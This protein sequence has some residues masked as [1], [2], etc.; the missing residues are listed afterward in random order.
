MSLRLDG[1]GKTDASEMSELLLSPTSIWCS[2]QVLAQPSPVPEAEGIYAW[3]FRELPP[4]VPH[5]CAPEFQ[6]LQ[7][8]YIGIS[9]AYEGSSNNLR[10]RIRTHFNGNASS[11]TLRLTLGCLLA[12]KLGLVLQLTGRT[13]RLTYGEGEVELS[14]WLK[15]NAY[16]A[17]FKHKQPWS[18]E[19]RI[20][21]EVSPL[22]NLQHNKESVFYSEL[23]GIR[24]RSISNARAGYRLYN[25]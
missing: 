6:G 21:H 9:P 5:G 20:I 18:I 4:A 8:L 3:Y 14:A 16:V 17:W 10:K 1:N 19:D 13:E 25:A 23:S 7:L 15:A 24:H 22:L 11:S 12:N 2:S